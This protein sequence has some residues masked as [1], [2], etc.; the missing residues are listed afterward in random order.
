MGNFK[1]TESAQLWI[2]A[3]QSGSIC[4]TH[5]H[6]IDSLWFPVIDRYMHCGALTESIHFSLLSFGTCVFRTPLCGRK[7]ACPVW[8]KPLKS[9]LW[10][11]FLK[12]WDEPYSW[13]EELKVLWQSCRL[14]KCDI[15]MS[16]VTLD[17]LMSDITGVVCLALSNAP[18]NLNFYTEA[19][20][21]MIFMSRYFRPNL[22]LFYIFGIVLNKTKACR[23]CIGYQRLSLTTMCF[24]VPTNQ[25]TNI[26]GCGFLF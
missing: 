22:V 10:R 21:R 1:N 4:I 15:T 25:Q 20:L 16:G 24:R 19:T 9:L 7:I 11:T 17:Y 2:M 23:K 5:T 8:K 12:N 3:K 13:F 6:T 18:F 14:L 26:F